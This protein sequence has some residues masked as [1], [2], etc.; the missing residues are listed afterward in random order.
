ME[1]DSL[2]VQFNGII[3]LIKDL[4]DRILYL[5]KMYDKYAEHKKLILMKTKN[6]LNESEDSVKKMQKAVERLKITSPIRQILEGQVTPKEVSEWL[7]IFNMPTFTEKRGMYAIIGAVLSGRMSGL[8]WAVR[9][10]N[11]LQKEM[12]YY[13][14]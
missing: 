10:V 14:D 13:G 4:T 3:N 6:I 1:Q 8:E 9:R 2:L 7:R 12:K 11:E 5:T